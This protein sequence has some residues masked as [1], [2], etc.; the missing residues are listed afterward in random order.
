MSALWRSGHWTRVEATSTPESIVNGIVARLI[1]I[2]GVSR[3]RSS[4]FYRDRG[5]STSH[6]NGERFGMTTSPTPEQSATAI[7]DIFKSQ[8]C[9]AG[10]PLKIS[11]VKAQFLENHGSAGQY[12]AGLMYAED[13]GWLE[14]SPGRDMFTLTDVGFAKI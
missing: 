9:I 14:V 11:Y 13:N 1:Y 4:F 6:E 8:N 5:R 2:N 10:D 12:E 3:G 7:L